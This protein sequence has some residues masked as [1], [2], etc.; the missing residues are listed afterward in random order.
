M[1][2]HVLGT[3]LPRLLRELRSAAEPLGVLGFT[4]RA[5]PVLPPDCGAIHTFRGNLLSGESGF[6]SACCGLLIERT[7]P[8]RS[9]TS[10]DNC[11][12]LFIPK[13]CRNGGDECRKPR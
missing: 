11:L 4:A 3:L 10:V 8:H 13:V 5:K 7:T 2:S 1:T 12:P 9:L 6:I